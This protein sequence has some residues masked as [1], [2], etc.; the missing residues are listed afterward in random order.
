MSNLCFFMQGHALS[1]VIVAAYHLKWD[2]STLEP[3]IGKWAVNVIQLS[4]DK[5]HLDRARLMTFWE[6]LDR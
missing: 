1:F 2:D 6:T 4:R 3:N 5:R